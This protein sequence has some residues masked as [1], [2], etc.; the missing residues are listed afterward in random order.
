MSYHTARYF[1][2]QNLAD[3]ANRQASAK[4]LVAKICFSITAI[5]EP[6]AGRQNIT[7]QTQN[8]GHSPKFCPLKFLAIR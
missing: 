4:I 8:L 5:R 6:G 7:R 2:G 3:L 1:G